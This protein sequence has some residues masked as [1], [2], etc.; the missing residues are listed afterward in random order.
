MD[1]TLGLRTRTFAI[2]PANRHWRQSRLRLRFI[3]YAFNNLQPMVNFCEAARSPASAIRPCVRCQSLLKRIERHFPAMMLKLI[4]AMFGVTVRQTD[5]YIFFTCDWSQWTVCST[6]WH[7][8]LSHLCGQPIVRSIRSAFYPRMR[9]YLK[10]VNLQCEFNLKARSTVRQTNQKVRS[11]FRKWS[12]PIVR[13]TE[14]SFFNTKVCS[15]LKC[16]PFINAFVFN[17][18]CVQPPS[19][20]K[21]KVRLNSK[22]VQPPK[23]VQRQSAFTT[24]CVHPKV[25]SIPNCMKYQSAHALCTFSCSYCKSNA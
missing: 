20:F 25:R 18:K 21:Q 14:N 12:N 13:S 23:C 9:S 19:T 6:P 10:C 5:M 15:T 2:L 1:R 8:V 22:C 16:I 24:K 17:S 11:N 7:W 3:K 4:R